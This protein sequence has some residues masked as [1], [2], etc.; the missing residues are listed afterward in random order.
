[1]ACVWR[2]YGVGLMYYKFVLP[3]TRALCTPFG[4]NIMKPETTKVKI[5]MYTAPITLLASSTFLSSVD[6]LIFMYGEFDL[7]RRAIVERN[8]IP[9]NEN[10]K[11]HCGQAVDLAEAY[12]ELYRMDVGRVSGLSSS[13]SS[14]AWL[15][16]AYST[17]LSINGVLL[18]PDDLLPLLLLLILDAVADLI[19]GPLVVSIACIGHTKANLLLNQLTVICCNL[20]LR[21]LYTIQ[22]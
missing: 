21:Q 6:S 17:A 22:S 13:S 10:R 8:M 2:V 14:S 7:S 5:Y 11:Q 15:S 18:D 4:L 9:A 16:F 3:S 20:P 1:M 12:A 19:R